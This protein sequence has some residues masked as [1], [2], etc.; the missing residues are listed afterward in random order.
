MSALFVICFFVLLTMGCGDDDPL[1]EEKYGPVPNSLGPQWA[2]REYGRNHRSKEEAGKKWQE[3]IAK[4]FNLETYTSI[5]NEHAHCRMHSSNS[6]IINIAVGRTGSGT[7]KQ[8]FLMNKL[9]GHHT[10]M[11]TALNAQYRGYKA[12]AITVR[13]PVAR[14]ISG[15]QRRAEGSTMKKVEN[16]FFYKHFIEQKKTINDYLDALRVVSHPLHISALESTYGPGRQSYMMPLAEYYGLT[17]PILNITVYLLCTSS[18]SDDFESLGKLLGWP[19]PSAA[20]DF[21]LSEQ[22]EAKHYRVRRLGSISHKKSETAVKTVSPT[23][24]AW[25]REIYQS[26]YAINEKFCANKTSMI[27]M[28]QGY[29][30]IPPK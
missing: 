11:C 13:D 25:V 16:R 17:N 1:K 23:N 2:H 12:I 3:S 10:T 5:L 26:D 6:S 20:R 19:R 28:N 8:A 29:I 18:L 24:I 7:L 21:Y 30:K 15:Y 22:S 9:P 4:P 14:I 27:R